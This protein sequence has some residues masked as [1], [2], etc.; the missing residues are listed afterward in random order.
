MYMGNLNEQSNSVSKVVYD[1]LTEIENLHKITEESNL[2]TNEVRNVIIQTNESSIKI[3]QASN[4]ISSIAQQTNLLALN[5]SIEA[6]RAGSA[7]KGFAVV[8]EEI[9]NL[10]QQSSVSTKEIDEIV[11]E[12]QHNSENAV[13]T[14]ERVS[15][16]T[17]QQYKSVGQSKDKYMIIAQ[18][19]KETE[20]A[21]EQLNEAGEKMES[22]K[23]RILISME[24]LSAVAEENS[25]ATQQATA[26]IE[27]QA[28]SAEEISSTS[29]ELSNMAQGLQKLISRFVI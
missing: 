27:E 12:L 25:A 24:T 10:A 23:D 9:K 14:I 5:A 22:M 26:S 6:A 19:M 7:G 18:S 13:K 2:A 28:A 17:G 16:I 21:V 3:G 20:R 1:G 15:A 8:A 29:E 4:V 11:S